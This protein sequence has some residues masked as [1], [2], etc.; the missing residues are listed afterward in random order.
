MLPPLKYTQLKAR[1]G[2]R[3][4]LV[5][6]IEGFAAQE[7]IDPPQLLGRAMTGIYLLSEAL[8]KI[9]TFAYPGDGAINFVDRLFMHQVG[10]A[11][12]VMGDMWEDDAQR[13][14]LIALAVMRFLMSAGIATKAAISSGHWSD[15]QGLFPEVIRRGSEGG[16]VS[17]GHGL[18]TTATTMGT[19]FTRAY[20]LASRFHG[21]WLVADEDHFTAARALGLNISYRA[22]TAIGVDWIHSSPSELAGFCSRAL[23]PNP[24]DTEIQLALDRYMNIDPKPPMSW[25][26]GTA[27]ATGM[28][29]MVPRSFL[30]RVAGWTQ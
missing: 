6:D 20:K 3:W 18:M 11:F 29:P 10:D 7:R 14:F 22:T 9:G 17:V 28:Y 23:L 26:L 21:G 1:D 8:Y 19:A 15:I 27:A 5:I 4:S 2:K 12:I 25:R 13:P 24:T 30:R 16:R